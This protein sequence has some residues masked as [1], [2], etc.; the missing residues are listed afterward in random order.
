MGGLNPCFRVCRYEPGGFF[1]PHK[2]GGF[3]YSDELLSL[4]TFMVY[5]NDG[6]EGAP[7][8]FFEQT[9]VCYAQPDP[10]KIIHELR[11]ETGACVAFNQNLVHDGGMLRAGT[12]YIL[13]TEV[14][15]KW[16]DDD[17]D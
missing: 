7:T 11:P 12:K 8:N 9:Q 4:K 1:L 5:L 2:D 16:I 17:F 6:F 10:T 13:R 3:E 14:M 15:Y